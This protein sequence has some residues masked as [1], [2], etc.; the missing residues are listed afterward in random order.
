MKKRRARRRDLSTKSLLVDALQ[1]QSVY[2]VRSVLNTQTTEVSSLVAI[3]DRHLDPA[4]PGEYFV[5]DG[6]HWS[7][8]EEKNPQILSVEGTSAHG[9]TP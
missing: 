9:V 7:L 6:T 3:L 2:L 1:S 8:L 5:I 4:L